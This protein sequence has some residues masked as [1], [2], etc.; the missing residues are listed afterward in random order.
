[1]KKS[2]HI[3]FAALGAV[4]LLYLVHTY[5]MHGGITGVKSGLGLGQ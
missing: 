2:W 3:L 1:M 4:G 5:M